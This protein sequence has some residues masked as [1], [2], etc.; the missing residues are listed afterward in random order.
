MQSAPRKRATKTKLAYSTLYAEIRRM[1]ADRKAAI[2]PAELQIPYNNTM[3]RHL[4]PADLDAMLCRMRAGPAPEAPYPE[5]LVQLALQWIHADQHHIALEC[6]G[7]PVLGM[8]RAAFMRAI[9]QNLT[10][11][12]LLYAEVCFMTL[13]ADPRTLDREI[14][15]ITTQGSVAMIHAARSVALSAADIVCTREGDAML[16]RLLH[17]KH[18]AVAHCRSAGN[19]F[20]EFP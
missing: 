10:I 11:T 1:L 12:G 20:Y 8:D 16:I 3:K 4:V 15:T 19:M 2:D 18:A 9:V 7:A 17:M 6:H 14:M 13:D 5:Q